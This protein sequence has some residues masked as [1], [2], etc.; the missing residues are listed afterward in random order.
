MLLGQTLDGM[1]VW[2]IR[3]GAQALKSLPEFRKSRLVLRA[4]GSMGV[5]AAYAALFEDQVSGLQLS[6]MPSS[7]LEAPDYLG[8]L[9]FADIPDVLAALGDRLK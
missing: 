3:C 5:N 1:R 2:D 8:I 9:R 6:A 4:Q 7:H